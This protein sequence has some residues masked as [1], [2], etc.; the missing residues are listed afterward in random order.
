MMATGSFIKLAIQRSSSSTTRLLLRSQTYPRY[1]QRKMPKY[2]L[3]RAGSLIAYHSQQNKYNKAQAARA[4][5]SSNASVKPAYL[6]P[7]ATS[8]H[9]TPAFFI[10]VGKQALINLGE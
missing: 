7:G 1:F 10:T 3:R 6:T 4:Y 9:H 2:C 8:Y 5:S